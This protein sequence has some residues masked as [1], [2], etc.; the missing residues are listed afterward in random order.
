MQNEKTNKQ[1]KEQQQIFCAVPGEG[2]NQGVINLF[3]FSYFGK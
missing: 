1:K 3:L 2:T